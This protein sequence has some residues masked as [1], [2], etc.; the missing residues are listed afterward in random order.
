MEGIISITT[1]VSSRAYENSIVTAYDERCKITHICIKCA[2]PVVPC[3]AP[4]WRRAAAAKISG[5]AHMRKHDGAELLK[6]EFRALLPDLVS[7]KPPICA[8][9]VERGLRRPFSY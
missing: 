2:R 7:I 6:N 3:S 9:N 4:L 8:H 5:S 1:T